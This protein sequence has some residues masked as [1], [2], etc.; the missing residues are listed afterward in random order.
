MLVDAGRGQ[1]IGRSDKDGGYVADQPHTPE[2]Y[3]ATIYEK[4]GIDRSRP[5]YT[6]SRRPVFLGHEGEPIRELA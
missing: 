2:D 4:L 1:S 3:A 6:A 5:L